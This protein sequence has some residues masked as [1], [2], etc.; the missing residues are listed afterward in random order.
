L[1]MFEPVRSNRQAWTI[2]EGAINLPSYHD[3]TTADQDRVIAV[4][5]RVLRDT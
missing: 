2:P 1:P 5:G 4:V 3:M